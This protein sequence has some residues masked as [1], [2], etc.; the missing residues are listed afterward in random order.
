MSVSQQRP[1]RLYLLRHA[2]AGWTDPGGR[3]FD[4]RLTEA[5]RSEAALMA[6][7]A[8][9]YG[10]RSDV[11]LSSAAVRCRETTQIFLQAFGK[12]PAVFYFDD[13]YNA[14]PETYLH[15]AFENRDTS[16]VMLVGHNPAI[17]AVAEALLGR[18]IMQGSLP[19]GFPTAALATLESSGST[20]EGT[21]A[22]RLVNFLTP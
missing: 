17:E 19:H 21:P 13:M 22:W 11:V 14:Q 8:M 6:G 7:A 5:G 9:N 1:F 10:Y 16:S 20:T 18:D 15:H 2:Q 12:D 4:R 3:D